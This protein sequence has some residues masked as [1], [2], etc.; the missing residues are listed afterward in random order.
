VIYRDI[1]VREIGDSVDKRSNTFRHSKP[2]IPEKRY[3]CGHIRQGR[4]DHESSPE[5]SLKLEH[6]GISKPKNPERKIRLRSCENWS[7]GLGHRQEGLR[8]EKPYREIGKSEIG[9]SRGQRT[10]KAHSA[11]TFRRVVTLI[12][13]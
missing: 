5:G 2:R 4:V 11:L 3:D 8:R 6:I 9:D 13:D 7:H 12:G 10:G 1:G